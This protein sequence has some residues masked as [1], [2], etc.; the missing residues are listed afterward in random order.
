MILEISFDPEAD[1]LYIKFREGKFAKNKR[2]E[3]DIVLDLDAKEKLLGIEILNASKKFS[4]K[5]VSNVKVK[6]PLKALA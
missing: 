5:E 2:I 1:A 6:L 3:E 4:K